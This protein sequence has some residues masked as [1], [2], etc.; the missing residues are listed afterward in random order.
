MTMT[1]VFKVI[2]AT[3]IA[4]II[5][6]GAGSVAFAEPA[7]KPPADKKAD[8]PAADKTDKTDKKEILSD[9]EAQKFVAFFDK[10]VSIVVANKDDCAKMAAGVNAHIDANQAL[11]SQMNDAKNQNKDL[12][13]AVKEKLEKK[14]KDEFLPALTAKCG[15]DKTVQAAIERMG[16]PKK[17]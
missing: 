15:K 16:A 3:I 6:L 10:L 4:M 7:A 17:K 11:M 14:F 12:P 9:A 13:A 5:T 1:R 2:A 8:K